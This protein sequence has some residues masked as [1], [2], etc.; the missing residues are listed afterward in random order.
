MVFRCRGNTRR[1]VLDPSGR[2]SQTLSEK[3]QSRRSTPANFW[4]GQ[5]FE[6]G[7]LDLS[8]IIAAEGQL[9]ALFQ[10][11]FRLPSFLCLKDASARRPPM[12]SFFLQLRTFK[13]DLRNLDKVLAS[14][15]KLL[16]FC[17]CL[18]VFCCLS[19]VITTYSALTH[20]SVLFLFFISF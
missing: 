1:R 6:S 12:F 20:Y 16:C 9:R 10:S 11:I 7:S 18:C 8:Q 3:S 4:T 2:V 5:I 19:V 13:S 17:V 14:A 15:L